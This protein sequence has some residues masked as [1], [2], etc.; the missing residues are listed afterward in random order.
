MAPN[1]VPSFSHDIGRFCISLAL[2]IFDYD[3]SGEK[4]NLLTPPNGY[5]T[6]IASFTFNW[7]VVEFA[8]IYVLQIASPT[9]EWMEYLS[10]GHNGQ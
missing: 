6:D 1:E 4:V 5:Q 9:F 7:E 10:S 8:D 2:K 3:I